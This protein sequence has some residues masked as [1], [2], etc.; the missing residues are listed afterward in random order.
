MPGGSEREPAV[1]KFGRGK[2]IAAKFL[3]RAVLFADFRPQAAL[4]TG[5]QSLDHRIKTDRPLAHRGADFHIFDAGRLGR[6]QQV[7]VAAQASLLD[8]AADVLAALVSVK[9][10]ITE[11]SGTALTHSESTCFSPGRQ[12]DVISTSPDGK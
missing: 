5:R 9:A 11:A 10:C 7:N 3:D 6:A 2:R 12:A 8:R 1:A 4:R